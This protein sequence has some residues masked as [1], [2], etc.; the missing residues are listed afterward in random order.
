MAV[1]AKVLVGAGR[2]VL[3]DV[4]TAVA[5]RVATV[6]FVATVVAVGLR[7]AVE[8]GALVVSVGSTVTV[9]VAVLVALD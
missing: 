2:A 1:G 7:V 8:V 5:R 6:D 3:I 9:D 4:L